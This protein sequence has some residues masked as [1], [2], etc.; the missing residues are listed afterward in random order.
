MNFNINTQDLLQ[1]QQIK[2]QMGQ[3]KQDILNRALSSKLPQ[4]TGAALPQTNQTQGWGVNT[5][6]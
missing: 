1:K 6:A 4:N 5:N 3:I 2:N